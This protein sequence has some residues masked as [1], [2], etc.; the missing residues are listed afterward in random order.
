M[1]KQTRILVTGAGGFIG[2]HLVKRLKKDGHWVRGVDIKHPEYEASAADDFQILDLRMWENCLTATQG[3]DQVY[4]LAAD[5]GGIG[6]ITSFLADISKN[7]ILINAHMLEASKQNGVQRFL[8]SSS[9]CVY[10]QY[11][12]KT[13][14]LVPL[15]EEDAYPADPEPGY[16][17]E[18]LFAEELCR[19]YYHD[20]KF[21]TRI[22]RFHNVY[23]PLGTYDGGKEKSPAAI[24][25]KV[26]SS[27]DGTIEIWG[28]GEQ[29]RSYMYV[30]DCVEGLIRLMASNHREPLNLGTDEMVSINH[31][32]DMICGIAGKNLKK[33]HDLNKPQGVRGRNSDNTLLRK[34]LGWEPNTPLEK[35][36]AVTYKWIQGELK[37]KEVGELAGVNGD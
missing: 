17:W 8:F 28:D 18:K 34:V 11:K 35:G 4:N 15:K 2:H 27:T 9:A 22:V 12:Q 1:A 10:A 25:R 3:M 13:P 36:L 29:T 24:S 6:Y 32:V 5:M 30:D 16:G 20:Y 33:R 31:L 37:K 21:E 26:A 23:G 7:N 14:D 19:Y